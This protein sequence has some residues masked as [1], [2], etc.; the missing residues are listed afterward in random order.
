[1]AADED[2]VGLRMIS[3][4]KLA[5]SIDDAFLTCPPS[6]RLF[7]CRTALVHGSWLDIPKGPDD[8][9]SVT[10]QHNRGGFADGC[11]DQDQGVPEVQDEVSR[12]ELAGV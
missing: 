1:M 6:L 12:E 8:P 9:A 2:D 7:R 10:D 5:M 3:W 4:A 11:P